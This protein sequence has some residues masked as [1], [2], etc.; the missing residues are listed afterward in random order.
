MKYYLHDS[1]SFQDEKISELYYE[2]GYEGL[3][4]FYTILEKL[5]LQEKPIKTIVLKKQLNIGKRLTKCWNFMESLG[6][7]YSSDGY[8]FNEKVLNV[9]ENYQIKK[10]KNREKI[11]QWRD[12]QADTKN[13]T[14]YKAVTKPVRNS[15]NINKGK[16]SK[17]NKSNIVETTAS[18]KNAVTKE[19]HEYKL[20]VEKWFKFHKHKTGHDPV[21]QATEGKN[22]NYI[23]TK[24]KKIIKEAKSEDKP[25]ELFHLVL[26]K[27]DLLD[28]WQ[29]ENCLDLKIFNSKFNLI[30]NKLRNEIGNT[31]DWERLFEKYQ[32][33][34]V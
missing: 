13:V 25:I 29:Q 32:P 31:E 7:L 8:T 33:N 5:A 15:P 22:I 34:N 2:F 14:G 16:L 10:Q 4:L 21:F 11:K 23:I 6:I 19:N 18:K 12:G 3:G 26:T 28:Q 27:W 17:I 20:F 9:A 1:N 30:I 24:F